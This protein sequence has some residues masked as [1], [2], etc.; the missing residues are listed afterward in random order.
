[1]PTL[2]GQIVSQDVYDENKH[3][4]ESKPQK[5]LTRKELDAELRNQFARQFEATW[6]L[7]GGPELEKEFRFCPERQWRADYRIG[8]WLIELDGGVF[9]RG[10]HVRATGFVEDCFK[11]NEAAILG[12]RVLRIATGMATAQY[13]Q[14]IINALG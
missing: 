10:R 3:I 12:Y 9:S 7:A 4:L 13:L 1:M 14:R 11:L 6:R 5:S 8:Q 2:F